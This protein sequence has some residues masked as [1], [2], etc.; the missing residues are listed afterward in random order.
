MS[1]PTI[2]DIQDGVFKV[3]IGSADYRHVTDLL[4]ARYPEARLA[5]T[6]SKSQGNSSIIEQTISGYDE[7]FVKSYVD[8][9][10]YINVWNQLHFQIS[11]IP[12]IYSTLDQFALPIQNILYSSEFYHDWVKPQDNIS[13][14]VAILLGGSESTRIALTVNVPHKAAEEMLPLITNDIGRLIHPFTSALRA[15][16]LMGEVRLERTNFEGSLAL[17]PSAAFVLGAAGNLLHAN[18]AAWQLIKTNPEIA[19]KSSGELLFKSDGSAVCKSL[20][21]LLQAGMGRSGEVFFIPRES[22]RSL[23]CSLIALVGDTM[24]IG[25]ASPGYILIITDP[26]ARPALPTVKLVSKYL[27]LSPAEARIAIALVEGGRT[28]DIAKRLNLSPHTVRNQISSVLGKTGC[29]K[30][31]DVAAIVTSLG[32]MGP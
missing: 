14:G 16:L 21:D 6:C 25:Q 5:L 9:Y 19:I 12:Q 3:A 15:R 27:N 23:V 7:S 31:A 11:N 26:E 28:A 2:Q 32:R 30:Q 29:E 18:P 1:V 13:E 17:I 10:Q 8:Y 24:G 4:A 20:A 22:Q